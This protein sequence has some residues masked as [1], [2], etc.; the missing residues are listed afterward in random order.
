MDR[1][2]EIALLG[3]F[4]E[5]GRLEMI[6]FWKYMVFVYSTLLSVHH[7]SFL[8]LDNIFIAFLFFVRSQMLNIDSIS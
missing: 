8:N 3:K 5:T 7:K 6:L 1:D 2:G 4:M